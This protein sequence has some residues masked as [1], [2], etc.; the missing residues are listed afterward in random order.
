MAIELIRNTIDDNWVEEA[1]E[2]EGRRNKVPKPQEIVATSPPNQRRVNL[3]RGDAVFVYDGGEPTIEPKSVGWIE[4]RIESKA[5]IDLYSAH[6]V[7]RVEG[8]RNDQDEL[9]SYGGMKGE[10]RRILDGIR[11]GHKEFLYIKP[12]TYRYMHGEGAGGIFRG[13][14]EIKLVQWNTIQRNTEC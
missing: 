5:T 1:D 9:E 3:K 7:Q 4:E 10:V 14:W 12:E 11:R 13:Q 6:S 8:Y 2:V